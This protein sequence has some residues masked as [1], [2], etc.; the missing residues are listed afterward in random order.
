MKFDSVDGI[1]TRYRTVRGSN[2]SRG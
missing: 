2:P 1:A